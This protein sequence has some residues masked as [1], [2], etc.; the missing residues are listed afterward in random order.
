METQVMLRWGKTGLRVALGALFLYAGARKALEPG[1]FLQSIEN[2]QILPHTAAVATAFFLPYLEIFCGTA[3]ALKRLHA[4]AL[5]L[6]GGLMCLFI[7]ALLAAWMRG[8]DIAC[9]CFGEGDGK[10]H[11]GLALTRDLAILAA[12]GLLAW[13]S[14]PEAQ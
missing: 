6:L 10:A 12:L 2:Y 4:G 11:Y 13:R 1:A 14:E 5:A 7:A 9:G 8:L 3:L